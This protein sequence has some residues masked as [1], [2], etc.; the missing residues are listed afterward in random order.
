MWRMFS[1]RGSDSVRVDRA[2]GAGQ[3]G[4]QRVRAAMAVPEP[5]A[6]DVSLWMVVRVLVVGRCFVLSWWSTSAMST[7]IC[8]SPGAGRSSPS[9]DESVMK[10]S[11][12]RSTQPI[13][14]STPSAS[15]SAAVSN[16]RIVEAVT[17][18]AADSSF[19]VRPRS[20]RSSVMWRLS[21]FRSNCPGCAFTN[22]AASC[23]RLK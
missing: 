17:P 8:P 16:R 21:L 20:A 14:A 1:G 7:R 5:C 23:S 12:V 18:V 6:T 4:L 13:S 15:A 19:H 3:I 9:T 10:C 2:V 22:W 11:G